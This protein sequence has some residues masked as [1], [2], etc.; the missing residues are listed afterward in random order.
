MRSSSIGSSRANRADSDLII[1]TRGSQLALWQTNHVAGILSRA[2]I[3]T[4]LERVVTKGD[5]YLD[6]PLAE[7]GDK[8]L[9][10]AE[11]DSALLDGR[12]DLAVHSLK[13]LPSE[14]PAGLTLATVPKRDHPWDVLAP[15]SKEITALADVP[16][17]AR[18]GSSS[19]RRMALMRAARPDLEISSIRGNVETRLQ[20]LHDRKFDAIILAEAGLTRLGLQSHIGAR[21]PLEVMVP[22]VGQGALG[23][24]C[25]EHRVEL[26]EMLDDLLT[27][28]DSLTAVLTERAFLHRLEGGCQVPIGAYCRLVSPEKLELHGCVAALDGSKVVRGRIEAPHGAGVHAGIELAERLIEQGADAILRDIRAARGSRS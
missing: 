24:V 7:I 12:I 22:A 9:F 28:A 20:K 19:L 13:D 10:T 5:R 27:D 8:G 14:L 2:G 21:L 18:I 4:R 6:Q 23:V 25:A 26:R 1:G 11:L 3:S 16:L 15:R 17:G